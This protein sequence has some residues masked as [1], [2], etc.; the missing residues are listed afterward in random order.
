MNS[1][2]PSRRRRGLAEIQLRIAKFKSSGLS[3]TEFAA[4]LGVH[5]LSMDRWLR[6]THPTQS[7]QPLQPTHSI[8]S[9]NT[10]AFVPVLCTPSASA[11]ST[12]GPESVAPSGWA[13]RLPPGLD[14]STVR[15]ILDVLPAKRPGIEGILWNG[16]LHESPL[17]AHCLNNP[18]RFIDRNAT[19]ADTV[20]NL[21]LSVLFHIVISFRV[22][23]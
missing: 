6:I 1:R 16:N 10:P 20:W 12:D 9:Q 18:V 22:K 17:E 21:T 13:L 8:A 7:P 3:K 5:S 23:K 15:S 2:V 11:S 4:R 19:V 14:P